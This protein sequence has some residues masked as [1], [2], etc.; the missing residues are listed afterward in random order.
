MHHVFFAIISQIKFST[1]DGTLQIASMLTKEQ[2][3]ENSKKIEMCLREI[4]REAFL[5]CYPCIP[6]E[7][8]CGDGFIVPDSKCGFTVGLGWRTINSVDTT[9]THSLIVIFLP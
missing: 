3:L 7:L 2:K 1:S 9:K 8:A 4:N 6:Q 5:V